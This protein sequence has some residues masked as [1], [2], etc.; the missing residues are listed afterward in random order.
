MADLLPEP[1]SIYRAGRRPQPTLGLRSASVGN[2]SV[3]C[4]SAD[5]HVERQLRLS[6]YDRSVPFADAR[7]FRPNG[8]NVGEADGGLDGYGISTRRRHDLAKVFIG[9]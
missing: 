6:G 8:R 9:A 7:R 2:A 1:K 5:N 4:R 3:T